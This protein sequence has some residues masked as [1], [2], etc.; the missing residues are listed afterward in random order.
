MGLFFH[1]TDLSLLNVH[2]MY[3]MHSGNHHKSLIKSNSKWIY[4]LLEIITRKENIGQ[5]E[6]HPKVITHCNNLISI[7]H[8]SQLMHSPAGHVPQ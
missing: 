8:I 5:E 1:L 4:R 3:L 2:T 6:G 7:N